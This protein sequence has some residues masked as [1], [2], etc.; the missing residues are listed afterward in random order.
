MPP[1]VLAARSLHGAL[2]HLARRATSDPD[3]GPIRESIAAAAQHLPVIAETLHRCAGAWAA[4][5]AVL[6]YACELPPREHNLAQRLAGH[7]LDGMIRA[8]ALD[9]QHVTEALHHARTLSAE[10]ASRTPRCAAATVPQRAWADRQAVPDR[11]PTVAALSEAKHE[12]YRHLHSARHES[13]A[14]RSR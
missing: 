3:S 7:R 12:A 4:T 1:V 6:A 9:L 13:A 8:D 2:Q 14:R 11:P 10:L 5:G